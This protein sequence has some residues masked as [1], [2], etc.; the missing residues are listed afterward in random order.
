MAYTSSL[1]HDFDLSC[2]RNSI[3]E[4]CNEA[5][6]ETDLI[7]N[8]T[9]ILMAAIDPEALAWRSLLH[10]MG[11]TVYNGFHQE[12]IGDHPVIL[13]SNSLWQN[14]DWPSH[15][16]F[17]RQQFPGGILCALGDHVNY[18]GLRTV[19]QTSHWDDA[20]AMLLAA[21]IDFYTLEDPK[22][23]SDI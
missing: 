16:R 2:L 8:R 11:M 1:R 17:I 19:S 13:V 3:V 5:A 22:D 9:V 14:S 10:G 7:E 18:L 20:R 23:V 21:G 12:G 6:L 15:A 4:S